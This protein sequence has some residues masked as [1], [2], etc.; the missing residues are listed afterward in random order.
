LLSVAD[1]VVGFYQDS[2]LKALEYATKD[3]VIKVQQAAN[4]AV[5]E[6]RKLRETYKEIE[7]KKMIEDAKESNE[8]EL[9]NKRLNENI[10]SDYKEVKVENIGE[11]RRKSPFLKKRMGTGGGY[12]ELKKP[13]NNHKQPIPREKLV[14]YLKTN[15]IISK[16]PE[17][18][19]KVPTELE[20]TI[21]S[22]EVTNNSGAQQWL[23]ALNDIKRG[24]YDTAFNSVL[25]CG[26]I[27]IIFRR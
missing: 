14:K 10:K 21:Q 12:I 18:V 6:W 16:E 23:E 4:A 5:K 17:L 3:R 9:I 8:E 24:N 13:I 2:I 25:S 1:V 19:M 26:I 15:T 22:K 20:Q 11:V 7:A 27:F